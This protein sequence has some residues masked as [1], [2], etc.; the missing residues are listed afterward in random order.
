MARRMQCCTVLVSSIQ[1]FRSQLNF[2]LCRQIAV[3][4]KTVQPCNRC[5]SCKGIKYAL[6]TSTIALI[7]ITLMVVVC[8][9]GP[10]VCVVWF[11]VIHLWENNV[12]HAG[13]LA[14]RATRVHAG[15][16]AFYM[17]RMCYFVFLREHFLYKSCVNSKPAT[18]MSELYL[19]SVKLNNIKVPEDGD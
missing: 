11:I 19:Q 16:S 17:Y 1:T 14:D 18:T 3:L 15:L 7:C 10:A 4:G 12:I 6:R 9:Q 2:T 13:I 8:P 5:T